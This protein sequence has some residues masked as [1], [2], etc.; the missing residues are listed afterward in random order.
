MTKK[1]S[2]QSIAILDSIAILCSTY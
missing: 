1:L 2:W